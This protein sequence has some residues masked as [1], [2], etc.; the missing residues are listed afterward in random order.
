MEIYFRKKYN[1]WE[2]DSKR[3]GGR[4]KNMEMKRCYQ[5]TRHKQIDRIFQKFLIIFIKK[6]ETK[7]SNHV[8]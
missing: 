2:S 5:R 3:E 8:R 4:R 6:K 1:V 7:I